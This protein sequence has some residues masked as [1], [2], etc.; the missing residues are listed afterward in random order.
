M[1][2]SPDRAG[3]RFWANHAL[4]LV[5]EPGQSKLW[6]RLTDNN[7]FLQTCNELTTIA[8]LQGAGFRPHYELN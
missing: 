3:K 5:P 1:A 2:T 4:S 7:H 8:I 6:G